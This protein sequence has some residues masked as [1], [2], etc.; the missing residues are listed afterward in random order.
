V[1]RVDDMDTTRTADVSSH[2]TWSAALSWCSH[3]HRELHTCTLRGSCL[4]VKIPEWCASNEHVSG[5]HVCRVAGNGRLTDAM[6]S[7]IDV[8]IC[9]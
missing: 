4:H 1:L 3:A 7:I 5:V 6:I 9:V 8:R 2:V